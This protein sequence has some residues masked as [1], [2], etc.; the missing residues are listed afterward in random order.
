MYAEPIQEHNIHMHHLVAHDSPISVNFPSDEHA[1]LINSHNTHSSHQTQP[2]F[3][4]IVTQPAVDH[5]S[6][7]P[8]QDM[9]SHDHSMMQEHTHHSMT[10]S[11]SSLFEYKVDEFIFSWWHISTPIQYLVTIC[12]II[13]CMVLY[14]GLKY[15]YLIVELEMKLYKNHVKSNHSSHSNSLRQT[16][17]NA[18]SPLLLGDE[19]LKLP[20]NRA[21]YSKLRL[22]HAAISGLMYGVSRVD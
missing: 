3:E 18:Q 9:P 19:D 5:L 2:S 13:L 22:Y 10:M 7:Y 6:H 4:P 21:L 20:Y 15:Y 11:F 1:H 14:H 8:H 12:I 16:F 17:P